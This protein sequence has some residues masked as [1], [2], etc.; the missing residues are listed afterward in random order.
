[1]TTT[2]FSGWA[3]SARRIGLVLLLAVLGAGI[4]A[5][6]SSGDDEGGRG[7]TVATIQDRGELIC[8]VKQTQPLFGNR[9][10]DGSVAGFDIEFCKALA[11]AV[12]GDADAVDYEDASDAS[13]RF[14]LLNNENID[15]LI[16]TTT[17]TA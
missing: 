4:A 9:E 13:T 16:R 3:V 8:G 1:M 6:C 11:A 7:D 17:I 2:N 5:A 15:V 14:E 10:A 12:L